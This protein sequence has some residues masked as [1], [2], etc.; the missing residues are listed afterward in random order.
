MNRWESRALE[1]TI[2]RTLVSAGLKEQRLAVG[3]E[4]TQGIYIVPT[5]TTSGD[6]GGAC[7]RYGGKKEFIQGFDAE[8]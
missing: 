4:T 2:G 1:H 7:G 3:I 6:M 5:E 8:T